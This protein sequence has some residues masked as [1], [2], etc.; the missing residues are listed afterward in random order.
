M[1]IAQNLKVIRA[2]YSYSQEQFGDLMN[3]S[4]GMIKSYENSIAA[5][6]TEFLIK[7][8][9]MVGLS[10]DQLT[11][12]NIHMEELPTQMNLNAVEEP[13]IGYRTQVNLFDYRN[14]VEEVKTLGNEITKLK[15]PKE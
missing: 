3:V 12:G 15:H 1:S 5:P 13:D 6:S 4:R 7:L 8:S 2:R 9:G 11:L 10:V 14:L